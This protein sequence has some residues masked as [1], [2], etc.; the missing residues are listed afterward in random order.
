MLASEEAKL[1]WKVRKRW[2]LNRSERTPV[3]FIVAVFVDSNELR[4]GVAVTIVAYPSAPSYPLE[5]PPPQSHTSSSIWLP[6]KDQPMDCLGRIEMLKVVRAEPTTKKLNFLNLRVG[7]K[8]IIYLVQ[9]L[10]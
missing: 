10:A 6:V 5:R 3:W 7:R 8:H 2:S 1:S 4:R 9:R